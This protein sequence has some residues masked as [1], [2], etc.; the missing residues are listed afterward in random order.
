MRVVQYN[1][2]YDN[3]DISV[4]HIAIQLENLDPTRDKN[5]DISHETGFR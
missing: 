4:T 5:L 3:H 2:D 1:H